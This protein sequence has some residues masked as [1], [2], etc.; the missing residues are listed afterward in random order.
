MT[1]SRV[2]ALFVV[3]SLLILQACTV[4]LYTDLDQ[5]QANEVVAALAR[6]GIPAQRESSKSGKITVSVPKDRFADAMSILSEN[7]LPKQSFESLGDV[8]KNDGLI[9]SPVQ[10]KARMIYGLSGELSKTILDIDGVLSAR[11]HLVLPENDPL[12]QN[13]VPSSASVFI[14]HKTTVPMNSLIPQVKMLVANGVAGLSYDKVSVVLVP[15]TAPAEANG[16]IRGYTSFLGLWLHPDSVMPAIWLVGGLAAI[17]SGLAVWIFLLISRRRNG[18]YRIGEALPPSGERLHQMDETDTAWHSFL[19]QP[20]DYVVPEKLSA[21]FENR[22][23]LAQCDL[24]LR[25]DRL[26]PRLSQRLIEHYELPSPAMDPAGEE[27]RSVALTPSTR[28]VELILRSGAVFRANAIAGIIDKNM[29]S[30]FKPCSV[31]MSSPLH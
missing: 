16:D 30:A 2:R 17:I 7:G 29:R 20:A 13:L 26:R 27:D 24:L 6:K 8:F 31:R 28:F 9:S 25:S 10:E 5:R 21:C 15:V 23:S 14:R 1:S 18:Q 22:I 4:E 11:V 12:R 3:V 19:D